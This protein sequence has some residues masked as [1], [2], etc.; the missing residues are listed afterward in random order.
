MSGARIHSSIGR[1]SEEPLPSTPLPS[2]P[3]PSTPPN[4]NV[5]ADLPG[6]FVSADVRRA[7]LRTSAGASEFASSVAPEV[8]CGGSTT[9]VTT[10][11]M[12][13]LLKFGGFKRK[14]LNVCV[15]TKEAIVKRMS[16]PTKPRFKK[17]STICVSFRICFFWINSGFFFWD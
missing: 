12:Q 3:L 9:E 6:T 10:E 16:F 13:K 14:L 11:Q 17:K 7:D 4:E 8:T 5:R 1:G 2:P 15:L